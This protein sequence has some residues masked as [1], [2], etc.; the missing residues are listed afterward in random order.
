ME[1]R[2]LDQTD[3][4]HPIESPHTPGTINPAL[5]I[6]RELS[7]IEFNRRVLAEAQDPRQPLLERIKFLSIFCS[8]LDEFFMIRVAGV[9]EQVHAGVTKL[10]P[11][12]NTPTEQ[13][14]AIRNAL[15]PLLHERERLFHQELQ[16]ALVAAGI[17]LLRYSQLDAQQR[18]ALHDYYTDEIFPVLTPLA[19]DPSH[20]F[21]FIS[22][23]SLS[24]AVVIDDPENGQ[25]FARVK[26]PEVLPRLL[27]LPQEVCHGASSG[28]H[29]P[30]CFVW[31]EEVIAANI[32]SLFPGKL[33]REVYAFRVTRDADI[34]IQEDEASDLLETMEASVRQRRFGSVVRLTV[35]R[36]TSD[37]VRRLLIANLGV[38]E[39]DTYDLNGPLGLSNLMALYDVDRP[40]LKDAPFVPS[41]P[42][43]LRGETDYFAVLRRQNVLLHHPFD[44]FTPIIDLVRQAAHD[45]QVLAIKMTLYR[46]GRNSPIV[47]A[48]M[49]A[50]EEGKQVAVLV[51]LKA[52]FDEE[53]NIEWA[54]ALESVGVH[55]S[56]GLLG[57]KTH[58]K[59]L[60]I[61]RKEEGGIRRYV[62]LGTGNY[63]ASTARMYTDFGMLTADPAIGA[64]VSELFNALTGYSSQQR[65]RKLLV[66][67][68]S[69]RSGLFE[70]I[71]REVA[72]HTAFGDGH[73]VFKF[74]GFT[75]EPMA[76][77]IYRAAQAGVK[78]DLLVR[79]MCCV[80]PGIPG[81]SE[82]VRVRSIVGRFLEH[83]RLYYFRNGGDE[84][85]YLGSADLMD[86]NLD[87]RVEE[88]FPI[89]DQRMLRYLRDVVIETYLR[90]NTRARELQSD[91]TYIRLTPD[92]DAP[93][94]AQQFFIDNR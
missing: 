76:M 37:V 16:P 10:S 63:N 62:H 58:A 31:L 34:E 47:R 60:L 43:A 55:V 49:E 38:A 21:P 71:E 94:D 88:L 30:I 18:A 24:L 4:V 83:H 53:N 27:R 7:W 75:D 61:V 44:S 48:L 28:S 19:I 46:V 68:V 29:P 17:H 33:V 93:I 14:T 40:D 59:L 11:D 45:P 78:V 20:P 81:L 15:L 56:Y 26:V 91:G 22:N 25:R 87:R 67:P 66:A 70:R 35:E 52:R 41:V 79:G 50:R 1:E 69:L 84:E 89:E 72:R 9:R 23:L 8:N 73:L 90:D 2:M 42:Q 13:L 65:Y 51:E 54:R 36:R 77:A 92:D 82:T 6:N 85:I 86:R 80:R 57:L 39:D 5:Y 74:N 12:G 32:A 3:Q 64:D